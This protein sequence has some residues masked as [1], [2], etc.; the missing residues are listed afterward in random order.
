[1]KNPHLSIS[2]LN[3]TGFS[4]IAVALVLMPGAVAFLW[5]LLLTI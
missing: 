2:E 3:E 1:M 5:H 4:G